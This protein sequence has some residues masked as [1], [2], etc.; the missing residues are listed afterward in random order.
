MKPSIDGGFILF[1][2]ELGAPDWEEDHLLLR[3]NSMRE[4]DSKIEITAS[5]KRVWQL[6]TDFDRYPQW[7][8]FIRSVNGRPAGTKL[9]VF[10]QPSGARGMSFNPTVL[11]AQPDR[12]LRWL[13][14]LLI[15]GLF[16]GEHVFLIEPIAENK[17]TFIQRENFS[18]LLVPLFWGGLDKDTQRGFNEMNAALK[19]LAEDGKG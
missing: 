14:H 10:I 12:E 9:K 19:K 15:S 6:L 18:G 5:A 8:P 3:S 4:L 16:D 17:V 1:V 2:F 7:N 11:K 13:G